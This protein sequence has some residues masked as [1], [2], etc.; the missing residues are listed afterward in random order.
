MTRDPRPIVLADRRPVSA[1]A[2]GADR[3]RVAA[4]TSTRKAFVPAS[5]SRTWKRSS[6]RE[7]RLTR[8][9]PLKITNEEIVR[10]YLAAM[11]N[12]STNVVF[13][14]ICWQA[15][16]FLPRQAG[17]DDCVHLSW[18]RNRTCTIPGPSAKARRNR[19]RRAGSARHADQQERSV[20]F[21][22]PTLQVG[23]RGC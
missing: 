2:V 12:E 10:R 3:S 9:I 5:R 16:E 13:E 23:G 20:L 14:R 22:H 4:I 15:S 7:R 8:I 1:N 17:T 11:M 21:S 6:T 19:P 18:T